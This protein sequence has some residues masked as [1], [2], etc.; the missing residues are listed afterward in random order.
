MANYPVSDVTK[1]TV[2]K[3]K[4]NPRWQTAQFIYINIIQEISEVKICNKVIYTFYN[5]YFL[6]CF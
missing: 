4:M 6:K 5:I 2:N 3:I 1:I